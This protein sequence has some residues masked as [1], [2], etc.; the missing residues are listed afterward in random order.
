LGIMTQYHCEV[1]HLFNVPP[2]AFHPPPKVQSAIVRLTPWQDSPWE[3]CE[4]AQLRRVVQAAFA[5][6][7]KTLRN[8][9]KGVIDAQALEA[10]GIDPSARAETL[11][12]GQFIAIANEAGSEV[13]Q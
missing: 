10:I 8:N 4:E 6:R 5:Q 11:E 13:E 3:P 1:E 9:M 12:L 7:R 2:E